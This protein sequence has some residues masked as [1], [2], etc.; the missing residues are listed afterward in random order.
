[1]Q[2]FTVDITP[3]NIQFSP[4]G[5]TLMGWDSRNTTFSLHYNKMDGDL[6][7]TWVKD[8][9][10]K[11]AGETNVMDSAWL[12]NGGG[13]IVATS[14]GWIRVLEYP[15]LN[16]WDAFKGHWGQCNTIDIHPRGG[17]IATG[18]TDSTINVWNLK[19]QL[20]MHACNPANETI[21]WLRFSH[22]GEWISA[23][24]TGDNDIY[25]IATETGEVGHK[26]ETPGAP[27]CMAW[28]PQ[29]LVLAACGEYKEN[30]SNGWISFFGPATMK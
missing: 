14:D 25:L 20:V 8:P 23:S 10:T 15:S 22:D 16:Q 3:I 6:R 27:A 12:H 26:I 19:E 18:G 11:V 5:K 29:K 1:V 2:G 28:N 9:E 21:Q 7:G 24:V 4:D 13:V 17:I 30:P